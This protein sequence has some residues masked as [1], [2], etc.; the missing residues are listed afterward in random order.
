MSTLTDR[1]VWGVLRAV[2]TAQRADLEPEIR[3]LVADAVEARVTAGVIPA[4]AERAAIAELGDPE[5]LAAQY[6]D[7]TL[8]LVGPRYF[9]DWKRLLTLLLSIVVPIVAIATMGAS[10]LAGKEIWEV[11]AS[12]LGTAFM[13]GI[14]LAFWITAVF[15]V[16]ER[17][18]IA[19]LDE[20][21]A[22]TPDKLP[23]PP[24]AATESLAGIAFSIAALVIAAIALVWQQ[25]AMPIT[26]DGVSYPLFN[27]D[28][29]SFWLPWLLVVLG[30]QIVFH[31]ALYLRGGWTWAFAVANTILNLAFL[32]PGIWLWSQGLL[33]DPGL[34]AA[35]EGMGL[36][37]AFRP[38][39]VVI[40]IVF[41]AATGWDILDGFRKAARAGQAGASRP[42]RIAS[43]DLPAVPRGAR[44]G[45][46]A[47]RA[48]PTLRAG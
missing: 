26:I 33:F 43:G 4:E 12:G 35:L 31:L 30:L 47:G 42:R 19:D 21:L 23:E 46:L 39:G 15:A 22:W 5:R 6:T 17:K 7:K 29:W 1:Y 14:N 28:L 9:P 27:P 3:A 34:V 48:L 18:E 25:T 8:F 11:V 20:E 13:V 44:P 37:E 45:R 16:M 36:A 41:I 24:A 32:V 38:A 2:P 40:A 10:L